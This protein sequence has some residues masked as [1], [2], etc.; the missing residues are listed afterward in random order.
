MKPIIL[1]ELEKPGDCATCGQPSPS[2]RNSAGQCY[3]C[4]DQQ[5]YARR[6]REKLALAERKN[7]GAKY[8]QARNIKLGETLVCCGFGVFGPYR[9]EGTA[10]SGSVGAY[11]SSK[12]QHG[13]LNPDCFIKTNKSS[14]PA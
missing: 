6:E 11:V 4:H 13:F 8:W 2:G 9:V 5:Y 14:G 12:Y 10:K 7:E 3:T 1:T